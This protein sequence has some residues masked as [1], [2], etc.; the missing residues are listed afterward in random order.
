ML[1]PGC[2]VKIH[3]EHLE[4]R[5][6]DVAPCS[7]H[8]DPLLARDLFVMTSSADQCKTWVARL[9][10]ALDQARRHPPPSQLALAAH[11]RAA[12]LGSVSVAASW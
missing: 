8:F 12:S 2:R 5:D 1:L 6:R 3:R 9:R 10:R 7:V 4:K 11:Q